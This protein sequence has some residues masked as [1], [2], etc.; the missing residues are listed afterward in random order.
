M[1]FFQ[2]RRNRATVSIGG[3]SSQGSLGG[4]LYAKWSLFNISGQ[5][6]YDVQIVCGSLSTTGNGMITILS[7]G[8]IRGSANQLYLVE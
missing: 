5:G 4:T 7:G 6:T 2:R 3:N 8:V 1:L